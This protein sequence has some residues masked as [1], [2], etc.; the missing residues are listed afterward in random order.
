MKRFFLYTLLLLLCLSSHDTS[1][2]ESAVLPQKLSIIFDLSGVVIETKGGLQYIGIPKLL[3]YAMTQNPLT[4]HKKLK[5]LVFDFL[6]TVHDRHPDEVK[7]HDDHGNLMPQC[8]CNWMKGTHTPAQLR[9]A[10]DEKLALYENTVENSIIQAIA[11]MIFT[12][13]RFCQTQH[14]VPDAVQ[15]IH[16]LKSAGHKL[17]ILSNFCRESFNLIEERHPEFF[18]LFD[19]IVI[20]AD[21]GSIKPDPLVYH[22]LLTTHNINPHTACFIDDQ[23][24]NLDAA[25]EFGIHTIHCPAK[26][27]YFYGK[28]PDIETVREKLQE[29]RNSFE[30]KPILVNV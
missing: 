7:A 3:T 22:H 16:E 30:G 17:Y 19:G 21:A 2:A 12:P 26:Y 13:E 20:S 15:L 27:G 8:M 29:W 10:V 5:T 23:P 6:H 4:L 28:S 24:I 25:R 14:L 18:A 11:H 1:S 9:A